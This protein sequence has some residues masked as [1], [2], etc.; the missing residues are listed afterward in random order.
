M[1][2]YIVSDFL[3][4][5][6][7]VW[8]YSMRGLVC[9]AMCFS[10]QSGPHWLSSLDNTF[11]WLWTPFFI[12]LKEGGDICSLRWSRHS[13]QALKQREKP[14]PSSHRVPDAVTNSGHSIS[15]GC[16]PYTVFRKLN[17]SSSS[18]LFVVKPHHHEP[19]VQ[20]WGFGRWMQ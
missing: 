17:E 1:R 8:W 5:I 12:P 3:Q 15:T 13:L 16:L 10:S 14:C 11:R 9:R 19:T 4:S 2:L 6:G 18:F 20:S 7:E